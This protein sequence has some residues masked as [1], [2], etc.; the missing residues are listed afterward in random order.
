[1][2]SKFSRISV[3]MLIGQI[4]ADDFKDWKASLGE[5]QLFKYFLSE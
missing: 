5:A 4:S 1:M 3:A 2:I